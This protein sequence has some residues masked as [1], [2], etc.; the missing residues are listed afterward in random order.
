[1]RGA[2][3]LDN[4]NVDNQF[5][6]IFHH[7]FV[8]VMTNLLRFRLKMSKHVHVLISPFQAEHENIL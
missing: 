1:M 6:F 3:Q 4:K 2:D 5:W 7:L 8:D